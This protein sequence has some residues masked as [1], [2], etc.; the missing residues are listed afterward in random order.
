MVGDRDFVIVASL[1]EVVEEGVADNILGNG[2]R[3]DRPLVVDGLGFFGVRVVLL[4]PVGD[5]RCV[6]VVQN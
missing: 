6:L 4:C 2:P 1:I 3:V 5:E